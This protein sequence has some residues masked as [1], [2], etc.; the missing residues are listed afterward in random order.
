MARGRR[1]TR[2]VLEIWGGLARFNPEFMTLEHS[3]FTLVPFAT[4]SHLFGKSQE[5]NEYRIFIR[6]TPRI[7]PLSL[8]PK[9]VHS[10]TLSYSQLPAL[11]GFPE[12]PAEAA[13]HRTRRRSLG[14]GTGI[15]LD[16]LIR[17]RG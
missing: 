15:Q 1:A 14:R 8:L 4:N 3:Y 17:E 6:Q 2:G 12:G 13:H 10:V 16:L 7:D 5:T 9:V 11:R